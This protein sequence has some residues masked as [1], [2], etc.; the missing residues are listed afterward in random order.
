MSIGSVP[1]GYALVPKAVADAVTRVLEMLPAFQEAG[2]RIGRMEAERDVYRERL[3][4]ARRAQREAEAE[5]DRLAQEVAD[6]RE[7]SPAPETPATEHAA[8][9]AVE[10]APAADETVALEASGAESPV[11]EASPPSATPRVPLDIFV[12]AEPDEESFE[13]SDGAF[14]PVSNRPDGA[15]ARYTESFLAAGPMTILQAEEPGRLTEEGRRFLRFLRWSRPLRWLTY[16]L[17]RLHRA[18]GPTVFPVIVLALLVSAGIVWFAAE[19]GT[20]RTAIAITL[21]VVG[22]LG[23]INVVIAVLFDRY[24]G[25]AVRS[26]RVRRTFGA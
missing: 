6:L 23:A 10:P 24:L 3:D 1:E 19:P 21:G 22:L 20:A 26:T 17:D 14:G 13:A 11:Q 16:P 9:L 4:D 7:G 15:A 2:E 5:R 18:V 12:T 8:P 25:D